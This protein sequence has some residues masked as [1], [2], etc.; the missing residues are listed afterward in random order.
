MP[1]VAGELER[2][3]AVVLAEG[4]A[5]LPYEIMCTI[6]KRVTRIYVRDGR[7]VK[8]TSLVGE[9][10]EWARQAADHFQRRAQAVAAARRG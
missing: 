8:L 1:A 10:A 3:G 6:G 7:P 9:H 5:T 4:S 2:E